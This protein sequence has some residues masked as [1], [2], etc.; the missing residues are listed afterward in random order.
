MG[1]QSLIYSSSIPGLNASTGA[2]PWVDVGG[3]RGSQWTIHIENY[4]AT[5]LIEVSNEIPPMPGSSLPGGVAPN[6]NAPALL[7]PVYPPYSQ[8]QTVTNY[9]NENHAIAATVTATHAPTAGQTFD[10]RGVTFAAGPQTG[11]ALQ[12]LPSGPGA[13]GTYGVNPATGVYSF[14]ATDV[15]NGFGVNLSYTITSINSGFQFPVAAS[16][17][18]YYFSSAA[19]PTHAL[20]VAKSDLNVKWVRVIDSAKAALAF[21]H[22]DK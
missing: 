1:Q 7:R 13:P 8:P 2:G 14:N 15:S 22:I 5:V 16:T 4:S 9:N 12:F 19:S 21:L 17:G 6:P 10:D 11:Y 3:A 20:F 18:P